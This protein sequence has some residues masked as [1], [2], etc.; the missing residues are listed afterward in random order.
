MLKQK[1][2]PGW[3]LFITML[4]KIL[5]III[6]F[7]HGFILT[8]LIFFPYPELF[9]YP[10]L[11]NH[12]LK[13]Y[14]QILDQ[15]FP[16]LMF[17]P[18]NLDNLG[19]TNE[20]VARIWLLVI[21]AVT[22]ILL[23]LIA[24]NILKDNK[25]A[26]LVNCLYLVWQPFFEGWVLWIDSFL[27][28]FLL[29]A[30]YFFIKKRIFITGLL[31]GLGIVFKQTLIPLAFFILIYLLWQDR[32]IKS[33]AKFLFGLMI[34][35]M[36]MLAYIINL[37]VLNDF[38]YWTIIFNLTIFAHFGTSLPASTGFVIRP[39]LVYA[40]ALLLFW[41][42]DKKIIEALLIFLLGSLLGIFDRANFI[43][44]QPSLP[45]AI[46][47]TTLG[48]YH[49]NKK[50]LSKAFKLIYIAI[51]AWWLSI[52]YKGHISNKILFFDDQTKSIASKI[53]KYV[54][55][56]EKIFI[57]GSVPHL[58]QMSKTL[59]TGDIFVF[60]FPWFLKVAEERL[61]EGIITD[62]PNII[63]SDR[64]VKIEGQ[65]ITEFAREIDQ[66][67]QQNYEPLDR[68]GEA[69]ILRRKNH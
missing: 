54:K 34:P 25:R 3:D 62:K 43:H 20:F 41:F 65:P 13:P 5:L 48:F 46:L 47:A 10:Y 64:T 9:I 12:G 17:M 26:L 11:T 18:I 14:S 28:V 56:D 53:Q 36:V 33:V 49:F 45:F 55:P 8:K 66:Y 32:Q 22:Q 69:F 15:H 16:G 52:F 31:I 23:F 63:V 57:F 19:M 6:I 50:N 39:I 29:T 40:G 7:F 27:P 58:Y 42:P 68:V 44:F 37:G 61:L 35:L 2:L 30:F 4:S 51:A 60:Q 67:I 24:K 21:V 38:W 59:P 1:I